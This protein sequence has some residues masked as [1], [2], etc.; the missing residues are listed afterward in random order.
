VYIIFDFELLARKETVLQ[1]TTDRLTG[2]GRCY[3]MEMNVEKSK[4]TRIS[5]QPSPAQ[6][7]IA[8]KQLRMWNISTI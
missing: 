3:G 6:N 7:M 2:T 1:G 5:W 8:Q 4:V